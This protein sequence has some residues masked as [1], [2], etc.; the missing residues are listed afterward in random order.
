MLTQ[1]YA[2]GSGL[3]GTLI[4]DNIMFGN[5]T[6]NLDKGENSNHS[7]DRPLNMLIGCTNTETGLF[8]TQ[9]AN[10]IMG[11]FSKAIRRFYGNS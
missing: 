10:G 7:I 1:V 11:L 6:D 2:E 4:M 8:P 9:K 5:A 3:Y